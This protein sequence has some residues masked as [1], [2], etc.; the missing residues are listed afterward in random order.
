ML[1]NRDDGT[2]VKKYN[3]PKA[4][5]MSMIIDGILT[6][7]LPWGL[8]LLGV[9]ISF[10]MELC[11][12]S[13]LAFAVGVY[14]PLSSSTPIFFGGLMRW[15][16]DYGKKKGASETEADSSPGVLMSSGL[17]AGGSIGGTILAFLA[18][19]EHWV[20]AIDWSGKFPAMANSDWFPYLP[21]GIMCLLVI[22]IGRG[23]ILNTDAKKK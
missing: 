17:I 4:R 8:V 23:L 7:K 16:A 21:F 1:T 13:S 19:K 6:Q 2:P 11:G 20:T 15:I 12:V 18:F 3:A 10:V 22:G 9:F 14:L 5:L